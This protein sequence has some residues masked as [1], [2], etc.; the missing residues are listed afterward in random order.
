MIALAGEANRK[1]FFGDRNLS[2][3]EGYLILFGAV[4]KLEDIN[5]DHNSDL[6]E[7]MK[8]LLLLFRKERINEGAPTVYISTT[9][10]LILLLPQSFHFCWKML[11]VE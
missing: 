11:A 3:T 2:L 7:F 8:R 5:V 9:R 6:P 4:P 1:V 10:I